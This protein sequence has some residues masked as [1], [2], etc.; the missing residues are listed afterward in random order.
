MDLRLAWIVGNCC[1]LTAWKRV[2]SF[3]QLF[4]RER[5][6]VFYFCLVLL[7]LCFKNW[8]NF[9]D[10][11]IRWCITQAELVAFLFSCMY[12]GF[13]NKDQ[14]AER[15]GGS[16]RRW[17]N[18]RMSWTVNIICWAISSA[19]E[20]YFRLSPSHLVVLITLTEF[21]WLVM[22]LAGYTNFMWW[23]EKSGGHNA[24]YWS[25]CVSMPSVWS[26]N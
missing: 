7:L 19:H 4:S 10:V 2:L 6:R 15:D 9:V 18:G 1:C 5:Y 24:W 16:Y 13:V 25:I 17:C 23:I 11:G 26:L 22:I 14:T 3:L 12:S 20:S 21:H 8:F